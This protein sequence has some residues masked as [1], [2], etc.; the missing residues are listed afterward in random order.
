MQKKKK[1][2][3]QRASIILYLVEIEAKEEL[4]LCYAQRAEYEEKKTKCGR[5]KNSL[6]VEEQK[7]PKC[8]RRTKF[9]KVEREKKILGC[10]RRKNSL[11]VEEEKKIIKVERRKIL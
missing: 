3:K 4:I 10:G 1:I 9:P 2:S 11:N 5:R 8:R 6:H 7:F